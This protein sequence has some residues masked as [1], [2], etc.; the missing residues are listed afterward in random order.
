MLSDITYYEIT[1]LQLEC[2]SVWCKLNTHGTPDIIVGVCYRSQAAINDEIDNMAEAIALASKGQ[3][4]IMSDFNYPNTDW[5]K[6][7]ANGTDTMFRDLI[8]DNYLIQHV[9]NPT[10]DQNILDLFL[11]SNT[12]MVENLHIAEHLGTV[13]IIL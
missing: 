11:T 10:R 9:K 3:L 4:L 1:T 7:E 8:L 5:R 2:E 6:L 13:T 12:E